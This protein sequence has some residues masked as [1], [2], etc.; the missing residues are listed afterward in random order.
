MASAFLGAEEQL[1]TPRTTQT[2]KPKRVILFSMM[3]KVLFSLLLQKPEETHNYGRWR[4]TVDAALLMSGPRIIARGISGI[5][6]ILL[7]ETAPHIDRS[8]RVDGFHRLYMA[9]A[10]KTVHRG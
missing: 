6:R 5:P 10:K 7:G 9:I 1:V 3:G 2:D 8:Y 4:I